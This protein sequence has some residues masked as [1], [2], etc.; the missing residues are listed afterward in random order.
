MGLA[1]LEHYK[2]LR[3]GVPIPT[4]HPTSGGAFE[5]QAAIFS[6]ILRRSTTKPIGANIK[7]VFIASTLQS[8]RSW[9]VDPLDVLN[10]R[11]GL[12]LRI[13]SSFERWLINVLKPWLPRRLMNTSSERRRNILVE[14]NVDILWNLNSLTIA[15]EVPFVL[16]VWDLQHRLQPFFPEVSRGGIWESRQRQYTALAGRSF[17][18][19]VGTQRGADE[20]TTFF[21]VDQ[22]RIL[23]NPFPCP[24][25]I[26]VSKSEQRTIIKDL[27]LQPMNYLI[28]PSQ[29]WP[30][31]NHLCAL[32]AIKH[33]SKAAR[34]LK[35]VLTGS[36][37]GCRNAIHKIVV[38]L[39][40]EHL[41][42]DA[43]FVNRSVLAALYINSLALI[44]PSYFGPDNIPPLEAM[45]YGI[46]AIVADVPG[47]A[48][49]YGNAV[50]RFNPNDPSD[51]VENV[52]QLLDQNG[53]R[54][55]LIEKGKRLIKNLAP[56]DYVDSIE[57]ALISR[58]LPIFCS[59]IQN[60]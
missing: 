23:V 40:M 49:Q 50:L 30:H 39:G 52:L 59:N 24:T 47:S 42:V 22:G 14:K 51:L 20:L 15:T 34:P 31:K 29:F 46:P 45:S 48:Q 1:N 21:G 57:N 44:Y 13:R 16:T 26:Q 25:P 5:F 54:A 6:E 55:E 3:V 17:L 35:L 60:S 58:R 38:E 10:I 36:D 4:D 8:V 27:S 9:Q 12:C 7:Y 32:L 11:P 53:L 43:G 56:S 41:V 28:Y 2:I 33:L 37:K 19:V 18:S